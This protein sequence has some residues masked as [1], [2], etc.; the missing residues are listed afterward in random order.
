[1]AR[2]LRRLGRSLGVPDSEE[3]GDLI[4]A[5]LRGLVMERMVVEGPFDSERRR[6]LLIDVIADHVER[7]A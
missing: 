6:S 3:L 7:A 2:G 4:W 5:F 1:M